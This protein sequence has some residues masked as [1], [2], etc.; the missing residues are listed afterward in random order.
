[1]REVELVIFDMDGLMFDTEVVAKR[2]WREVGKL[3]NYDIT[4]EFLLTL[5]GRNK[6]SVEEEFKKLFGEDFPFDNMYSQ[7]GKHASSIIENEGLGIK[8]GLIEL[9]D[10]LREKKIKIAV[11]TSTSRERAEKLLF[12][13]GVLEK[14]DKVLCGDEVTK[15]KPDPEIF[16]TVCE[17][18]DIKPCNAL[19][20]EDSEK[21]LEAAVAGGIKCIVVPDL[22]EPS[23]KHISMA[24]SKVKNLKEVIDMFNS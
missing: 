8:E 5:L 15:G 19:V 4:Q 16:L 18:L 12:I 6:K 11:A 24:H 17:K 2:A 22:M 1:M 20:L 13:A 21:G 23:E 9:I 3:N 7:Q 14:F 10:H